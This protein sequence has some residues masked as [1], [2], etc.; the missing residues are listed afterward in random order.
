MYRAAPR[1]AREFTL[2]CLY[3][4]LV[5]FL[6]SSPGLGKSSI[7]K[8]IAKE[9]NLKLIDHRLSTSA[10]EDL[11]GLPRFD[12]DGYAY[13][14]P[15]A[16][17]FPVVG[18]K[19]PVKIPAVIDDHGKVT[20]PAEY[21]DG[22]LVF[23]D[24]FNS[25]TKLVQAAAY[26]LILDKQVGQYDLHEN[27]LLACAGNLSTDRALVNPLGTAMQSRVI[28]IEMTE[29]FEEWLL[30]VALP[31][32][33]DSRVVAYL[34]QYPSKLM[35]FRPDHQEKTFC[36]PRTWEFMERLIQGKEV[37]KR[38]TGL[39]AGTITSGVAADFVEFTA[40]FATMPKVA[41]IL[42]DPAG[43]RV[44]GDLSTK[45]AVTS[46]L[47]EHVDADNLTDLAIYINRFDLTFRVL[48]FR[49]VMVNHKTLRHHP[50]FAK[51]MLDLAQ[52]LRG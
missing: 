4:G 47:L 9:L 43:Y 3:A 6:Q 39:Y 30:D 42:K 27:C 49:S 40:V 11:S 32:K 28:H 44:P 21:Y 46:S 23:L 18:T 16:G 2:D 33:Y 25:A 13:F 1:L 34:S 48:F 17:L 19:L 12:D 37:E 5:P 10:P 20:K 31:Q 29:S 14:A 51:A 52:Y 24:E 15:F 8:S 45:W 26:K 7:M 36:C 50:A 41:E 35:D 22:W 38:K